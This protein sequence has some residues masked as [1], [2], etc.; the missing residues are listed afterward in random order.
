MD[1][2]EFI[3]MRRITEK[4]W[5]DEQNVSDQEETKLNT[6]TGFGNTTIPPKEQIE[7]FRK[8]R[9]M[10]CDT[11]EY[12]KLREKLV[13]ANLAL[14][15]KVIKDKVNLSSIGIAYEELQSYGWEGLIT[16]V[17]RFDPERGFSFSTF[18]YP[19]IRK[20][21]QRAI[22]DVAYSF[23]TTPDSVAD[24]RK[25]K[26]IVEDLTF[27]NDGRKPSLEEVASRGGW[28]QKKAKELS[29][30][31]Y[32]AISLDNAWT[33]SEGG[34]RPKAFMNTFLTQLRMYPVRS[35]RKT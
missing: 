34:G 2:K 6:R 5:S 9:A 31:N 18:A 10:D 8:L 22:A 27:T 33:D 29:L 26:A 12:I 15:D 28:S 16:A 35:N 14:V 24:M 25:Y 11:Q 4:G 19:Y 23:T 21:L 32:Y 17:D 20:F 13:L 30:T 3:F 1:K 7:L